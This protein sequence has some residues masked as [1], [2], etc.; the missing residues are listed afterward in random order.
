MDDPE[1]LDELFRLAVSAID[2][3]DVAG[4]ER[5]VA[6][7][8]RLLRD[9]LEAPG[10]WLR[11]KVGGAVDGFFRAP[12][13]L[14][15]IA[16][17]PA[18]NGVLPRNIAQVA[19]AIIGAAKREGAESLPQQLEGA[20][21]LVS[22][23]GVARECG[24]QIELI[25]VLV[26][27]G[28]AP[29]ANADCALVNGH[30]EAAAHL[31]ARGA[32]VTLAT[33]LCLGRWDD[34]RRLHPLTSDRD[35]QAAFVLA[36]LNGKAEALRR[37]I[38]GGID[39][40]RPSESLHAHGTPLHHAVCS[41][42]L[43]AV[44]VLVAAGA[45]REARDAIWD[46]TPLGWAEHCLGEGPAERRPCYAAIAAYLADQPAPP[47]ASRD[48]QLRDV[49]VEDLPVLFEHQRD[50]Q[51]NEMAAFSPRDH[52]AF[53]AHWTKILGDEAVTKRAIVLGDGAVAGYVVS[54]ATGGRTLVGYWVGRAHWGQGVATR[55]LGAFVG[56]ITVRPLYAFVAKR[57]G[58]S[59]RVL[60][61]CGFTKCGESMG[62]PDASGAAVEEFLM[63]LGGDAEQL[64]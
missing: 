2:A 14:W 12:Y 3:G 62:P 57:N 42:S 13:L 45:R 5:L 51:A 29:G 36:A 27:A 58:A 56:Q 20:L 17:D 64:L 23:S 63:V 60:E 26:D 37:M 50:P 44:K 39:V 52:E 54:Y 25:D 22:W 9:R 47:P 11:D 59:I 48:V 18:R 21:Q 4:I 16:E 55:A 10:A 30:E 1:V 53:T 33:A 61:K 35:R 41:G 40:N 32:T 49:T 34:V 43:D 8:P 15:F 31:V 19:R 6:D 28:A 46:G 24:V 38:A 7:H